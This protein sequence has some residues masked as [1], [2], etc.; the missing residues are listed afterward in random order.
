VNFSSD[1]DVVVVVVI[2]VVVVVVV[3]RLHRTVKPFASSRSKYLVF[4]GF[5]KF[6]S[7]K[8]DGIY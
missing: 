8:V 3:V 2:F 5:S 4:I 7:A 6:C 1:A